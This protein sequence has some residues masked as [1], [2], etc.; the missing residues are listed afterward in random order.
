[1]LTFCGI[2][3]CS[4][5][6]NGRVKL[7][8]KILE[9]FTSKGKDVVLYCLPEGAIAVYPEETYLKIRQERELSEGKP[10]GVF[11]DGRCSADPVHGLNPNGF[12]RRDGS[13]FLCPSGNM[14]DSAPEVRKWWSSE[15]KSG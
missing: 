6:S 14:P 8:P 12:P 11:S 1:M 3:Y 7:S 10:P 5:D 13:R 9:D 4:M 15:W 2:D